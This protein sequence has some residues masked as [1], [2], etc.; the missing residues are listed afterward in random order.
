[1]TRAYNRVTHRAMTSLLPPLARAIGMAPPGLETNWGWFGRDRPGLYAF[2]PSVLEP[3]PDWPPK[4]HVTG[5]WFWDRGWEAPNELAAFLV[6]GPAPIVLTLGSLWMFAPRNIV[7]IATAAARRVG[8]R[9][10][11]LGG[12]ATERRDDVLRLSSDVDHAWLFPQVAAVVHHGAAGTTAAAARSGVPQVVLPSYGDQPFWAGRMNLLDV[13][14]P[15]IPIKRL[16]A[17]R[18]GASLE[19]ALEDT[20]IRERAADLGRRIQRERG[21]RGGLPSD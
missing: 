5:Y 13:A 17:E 20:H 15:P 16:Q 6:G 3:P 4:A 11:L 19:R 8:G 18:L 21:S 9:L 1:M 7:E 2:S 14:P 10:L 12:P